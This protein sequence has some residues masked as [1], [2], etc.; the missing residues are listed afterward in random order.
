MASNCGIRRSG[1]EPDETS[2]SCQHDRK[3]RH[4]KT[5][6]KKR[7]EKDPE[8][9]RDRKRRDWEV[10]SQDLQYQP[11]DGERRRGHQSKCLIAHLDPR[12]AE[13]VGSAVRA[14]APV[15]PEDM[16]Q[17]QKPQN[18]RKEV[19]NGGEDERDF[20][21]DEETAQRKLEESRRRREAM[22]AK[23]VNKEMDTPDER[24]V[25]GVDQNLAIRGEAADDAGSSGLD[26]EK[27]DNEEL[28]ETMRARKVEVQSPVLPAKKVEEAAGDMFDTRAG[29]NVALKGGT[30]QSAEISLTGASGDDWDDPEGY[31]LAKVGEVLE[32]RYRVHET[33]C[34]RGVFSNVVK[35]RDQRLD[36]EPLVAI[37]IIRS[38]DMMKKA[39]EKEIEIL[40]RLNV[41]DK[42]DRRHVIRLLETFYYRKHI[43]LVF[44]CMWD[45][46]RAA[47]K[48]HTKNK[49]MALHAVRAY[50]KQLLIGVRHMHRCK[51]IH[52]DIKPDNVLIS[53]ENNIVKLCDLG[54]AVELK[55]ITVSPY[56]MS[57]FYRPPEVILGCEY[58][59]AVDVWAL[60]CTLYEIFAGKTLLTG[61]TN[62]DQLKRIMDLKGKIP[63]RVIKKGA[64]WKQHF[65]DNFDFK[66]EDTDK[67]TGEKIMRTIT[68]NNAKREL[69]ELIL[70]RVGSE[71]RQ[72]QDPNDQQY[73]KKSVHFADLLDKM[74]ALDPEKRLTAEDALRHHFL[75]EPAPAKAGDRRR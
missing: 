14:R 9:K 73:V 10:A 49:G 75:S 53:E 52:A 59:I 55:D 51:I 32:D 68:D 40:Q 63:G 1:W 7:K 58:G 41:A 69:K 5:E 66:Y 60:S 13:P 38:N 27:S 50:T 15:H 30:G 23:W 24:G 8:R 67:V 74:L 26:A 4:E 17:L 35:A 61:K 19:V 18:W 64:V 16:Q 21:D 57:R 12:D 42:G 65:D 3:R 45:D 11:S 70:D 54:T 46:L 37:K 43:F 44:E 34:G 31:Y 22:M 39:A 36:G 25:G 71:K 62:N 20:S 72:S 28:D 33:L 2:D 6:K 48:K 47:L 56:L 29:A